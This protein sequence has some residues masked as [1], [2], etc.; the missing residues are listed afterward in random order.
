M[1]A[2]IYAPLSMWVAADSPL[3]LPSL[4]LEFK[5]TSADPRSPHQLSRMRQKRKPLIFCASLALM[6][7]SLS[8]FF[9]LLCIFPLLFILIKLLNLSDKLLDRQSFVLTESVSFATAYI[10]WTCSQMN[11]SSKLSATCCLIVTEAQKPWA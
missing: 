3:F 1:Y 11:L 2:Y 5:L 6:L 4:L 10:S 8:C 7:S 9:P